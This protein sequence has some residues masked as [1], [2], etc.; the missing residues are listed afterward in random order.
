MSSGGCVSDQIDPIPP[1]HDVR[2]IRVRLD[3][4]QFP[5]TAFD[6]PSGTDV[7]VGAGQQ[8]ARQPMRADIGL[9]QHQRLPPET[10]PP[11]ARPDAVTDMPAEPYQTLVQRIADADA[12]D[13][14]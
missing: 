3:V 8:H 13:K 10:L 1:R 7:A 6:D 11:P 12:P 5:A 4:L 9:R 14:F 2:R